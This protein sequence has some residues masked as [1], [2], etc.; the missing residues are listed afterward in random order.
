VRCKPRAPHP[1]P[2]QS[3]SHQL[4]SVLHR[5]NKI[6]RKPPLARRSQGVVPDRKENV[7]GI[8]RNRGVTLKGANFRRTQMGFFD[9]IKASVGVG[10][11]KIQLKVGRSYYFSDETVPVTVTL[12]GGKLAQ[13]CHKIDLT[14]TRTRD[15]DDEEIEAL[16]AKGQQNPSTR[17][18]ETLFELAL[19]GSENLTIAPDSQKE[20]VTELALPLDAR[21][22]FADQQ[23][24]RITVSAD[25][26][27]AIDPSDSASV[28]VL[29]PRPANP[30][31]GTMKKTGKLEPEAF[32]EL[33]NSLG[34]D[35][36]AAIID[37]DADTWVIY[38]MNVA[39]IVV[40][41]GEVQAVCSLREENEVVRTF[42]NPRVKPSQVL[43][44]LGDDDVERVSGGLPEALEM[45]RRVVPKSSAD[46]FYPE[47][48][49]NTLFAFHNLHVYHGT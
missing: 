48:F 26:P 36:N 1:Q 28:K 15:L 31:R 35:S 30:E 29:P 9:K 22:L 13:K 47:V 23:E 10:G 18:T 3:A 45:A 43:G 32:A 46:A 20:F 8:L 38:F 40:A 44:R 49:G 5:V 14:L 2:I 11:A 6:S 16:K 42:T 12:L 25:I 7:I 27:G 33:I 39:R 21:A 41:H 37:P 17:T 19:P 4:C 34:V 24:F